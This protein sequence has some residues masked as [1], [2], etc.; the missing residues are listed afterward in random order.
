MERCFDTSKVSIAVGCTF[1]AELSDEDLEPFGARRQRPHDPDQRGWVRFPCDAEAFYYPVNGTVPKPL[2]ARAFN[3]SPV[4]VG[5][6]VPS[7]VPAGTLVSVELRS[8]RQ[9][10]ALTIMA[11]VV[12]VTGQPGGEWALGCNFIRELSEK[13]LQALL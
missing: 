11:S 6:L 8:P 7:E 12:R 3:I 5:L 9:P 4:G 13:E 1:A 2:P 10:A